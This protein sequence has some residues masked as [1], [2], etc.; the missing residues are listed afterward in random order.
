[1]RRVIFLLLL[2]GSTVPAIAADGETGQPTG[3]W[4]GMDGRHAERPQAE[5]SRD[6]RHQQRVWQPQRTE[7][8][9]RVERAVPAERAQQPARIERLE[10]TEQASRPALGEQRRLAP[11]RDSI[12]QRARSSEAV[13]AAQRPGRMLHRR[14]DEPATTGGVAAVDAPP[15]ETPGARI[16]VGDTIR[17]VRERRSGGAVQGAAATTDWRRHQRGWTAAA[18]G[19]ATAVQSSGGARSVEPVIRPESSRSSTDPSW[20]NA[21]RSGSPRRPAGDVSHTLDRRHWSGGDHQR[22][23]TTRWRQDHRYDWR[24]YRNHHRSLFRQG[25]YYDPFGFGYQRFMTGWNIWP[26]YYGN[27]YWI[28]DPWSYRLPTAYGP[29]RWV[30]YH[31]DALLIDLYSGEVVDVIYGFF[32]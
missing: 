14:L 7:R 26:A 19:E 28:N 17:T 2:A 24:S 29:Y 31:D 30:R 4:T 16:R 18:A 10:R 20:K 3:G 21:I 6:D 11:L 22:L 15:R 13:R 27:R 9:E 8:V 5:R 12:E 32:W 1:M 23:W 25:Y